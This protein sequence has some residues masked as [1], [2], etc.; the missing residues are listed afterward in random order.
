V[1]SDN[2]KEGALTRS[3]SRGTDYRPVGSALVAL[4]AL[5]STAMSST[6]AWDSL[7]PRRAAALLPADLLSGEH[8]QIGE[9]VQTDGFLNF[10][11][12]QTDFGAFSADSDWE[13]EIR[14]LEIEAMTELS[15]VT[16]SKA[17]TDALAD[18][19]IAPIEDAADL[20]KDPKKTLK[21]LGRGVSDLFAR[22]KK[23]A[24]Q[25]TEKKQPKADSADPGEDQRDERESQPANPS[26]ED[27]SVLDQALGTDKQMRLWAYKLRIDPYTDNE[28]LQAELQRV[29]EAS[30][31]GGGSLRL[32]TFDQIEGG[33]P[34]VN[35]NVYTLHRDELRARNEKILSDAGFGADRFA[36]F[37]AFFESP[38][39]T[40][41]MRTILLDKFVELEGVAGRE[42]LIAMA[43]AMRSL[44]EARFQ[45]G[46]AEFLAA[47]HERT[48]LEAIQG[49]EAVPAAVTRGGETFLVVA[50]DHLSWTQELASGL[51]P[52]LEQLRRA[53]GSD[54]IDLWVAG[55]ATPRAVD[56]LAAAGARVRISDF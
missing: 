36:A 39:L 10:Y 51:E 53:T 1:A 17:F 7:E 21:S 8:Y 44:D 23:L 24:R 26:A 30:A 38:Q 43:A 19:A 27:D 33:M 47:F 25:V 48:P 32:R 52:L 29:A 5:A 40:P 46:H 11:D 31:A 37:E 15:K 12:L 4:V 54:T 3:G 42:E 20:I 49:G 50:A 13:L 45:V 16:K 14:L 56:G 35:R 34:K 41:T 28:A 55:D 2:W 22:S 9:E 6:G 18:T